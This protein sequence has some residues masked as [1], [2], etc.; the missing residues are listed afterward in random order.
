MLARLSRIYAPCTRGERGLSL[1]A[2]FWDGAAGGNHGVLCY[3]LFSMS[4]RPFLGFDSVGEVVR[5]GECSGWCRRARLT[6]LSENKVRDVVW[7]PMSV[8]SFLRPGK[9]RNFPLRKE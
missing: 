1:G 9:V 2:G 4:L 3:L 5:G 7:R 6:G 8:C